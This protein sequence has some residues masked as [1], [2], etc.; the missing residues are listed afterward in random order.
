MSEKVTAGKAK[1]G[2]DSSIELLRIFAAC[3]VVVLHYNSPVFG[4][5]IDFTHGLSKGM[6]I[7]FEA[8]SICAV[9]IFVLISGYFMCDN[10]KRTLLKP[11]ELIIQVI[12][13]KEAVYLGYVILGKAEFSFG[14][15]GKNL[16]PLNWFVILYITL[17][18]ISPFL[19]LLWDAVR[20]RGAGITLIIVLGLLFSVIPTVLES[21]AE[22]TG[23]DLNLMSTIGMYGSMMGYSIVNFSLVYLIGAYLHD[24]KEK[25]GSF[26]RLLIYLVLLV[27]WAFAEM[28]FGTDFMYM[29][30]WYYCNPIV[31]LI[32]V[33]LLLIFRGFKIGSKR[34][35]NSLASASF[36]VYLVHENILIFLRNESMGEW[37]VLV[38]LL[39][40]LASVVGI[41]LI[42][43]LVW[44]IYDFIMSRIY[45]VTLAKTF[46]NNDLYVKLRRKDESA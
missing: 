38:L 39:H 10:N 11:L 23:T 1:P 36:T 40:L 31:I 46:L 32:A 26:I 12:L 9:D 35:I 6:L 41:Y 30:T 20:K 16:I 24:E 18:F 8:L 33:E 42:C 2:R 44:V 3:A 43:Y 22:F 17:Y 34:W 19:N 27:A 45:K 4:G 29:R 21:V 5:A 14:Q 15:I 28:R 7:G 25:K 37:N 13:I